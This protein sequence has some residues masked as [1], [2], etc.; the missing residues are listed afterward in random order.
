MGGGDPP[1]TDFV[2]TS[3]NGRRVYHDRKG[4]FHALDTGWRR[5]VCSV[6]LV[7]HSLKGPGQI[8]S[9]IPVCS[10]GKNDVTT[11]VLVVDTNDRQRLIEVSRCDIPFPEAAC[12]HTGEMLPFKASLEIMFAG[13]DVPIAPCDLEVCF[14]ALRPETKWPKCHPIRI[15]IGPPLTFASVTNR[16][17]GWEQ[18]ATD[19]QAAVKA[20]APP[21]T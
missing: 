5:S 7:D 18:I 21:A 14:E 20:L 1:R 6:L 11:H 3:R 9:A 15:R 2:K 19:L 17:E 16:R 10:G 4:R 13:T 8:D 12:S